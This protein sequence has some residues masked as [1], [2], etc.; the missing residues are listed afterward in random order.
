MAT[1]FIGEIKLTAVTGT[2]EGWAE[3][4]GQLL[5]IVSNTALFSLLGTTYGGDGNTT[6]GLPDLRG[7]VPIGAG[8]GT[9]LTPR[10]LGQQ[11]GQ[12]Q[13]TLTANEIPDHTHTLKGTSSPGSSSSPGGN[14]FATA[15][16][17]AYR[18]GTPATVAGQLNG[19]G[20]GAHENM[21]PFQTVRYIIA[22]T[23]LFPPIP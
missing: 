2:P 21:P 17:A 14:V 12:E 23:G 4:D 1:P 15:G 5:A 7:R 10:A 20:F 11:G 9:G 16:K 13:V 18:D 6:F 19:G 22:L 3:C 8:S